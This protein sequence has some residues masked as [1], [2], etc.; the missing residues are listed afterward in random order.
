MPRVRADLRSVVAAS[1]VAQVTFR[2]DPD[3]ELRPSAVVSQRDMARAL[4]DHHGIAP[5]AAM[6]SDAYLSVDGAMHVCVHLVNTP[7]AANGERPL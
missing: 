3:A 5:T 6:A 7:V 2:V 4:L 1:E